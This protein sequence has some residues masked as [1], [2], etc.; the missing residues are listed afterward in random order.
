MYCICKEK[1]VNLR[2]SLEILNRLS[3]KI[4]SSERIIVPQLSKCLKFEAIRGI[5]LIK[6]PEFG[7]RYYKIRAFIVFTEYPPWSSNSIKLSSLIF[8]ETNDD[9]ESQELHLSTCIQ[10]HILAYPSREVMNFRYLLGCGTIGF[11]RFQTIIKT[12]VKIG[13]WSAY[14][15]KFL[16]IFLLAD[17]KDC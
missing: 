17:M 8:C 15:S 12:N 13:S 5:R 16:I 4:V 14:A 2:Y 3:F 7:Q 6:W 10:S 1:Q 11:P 9:K